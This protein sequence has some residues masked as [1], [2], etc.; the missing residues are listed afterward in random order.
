MEH[1]EEYKKIKAY[2]G[3]RTAQRSGVKLM[4]HIEEGV[5][6]LYR[7]PSSY[8]AIRAFMIHPIVQGH[9]LDEDDVTDLRHLSSYPLA[10]E[11]RNFANAFL[12]KPETDHIRCT[13]SLHI[14]LLN[15]VGYKMSKDCRD[16]LIADKLQNRK[17][18]HIYHYGS[19]ARSKELDEYFDT[20]LCY[21]NEYWT[22]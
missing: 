14:L 20:W 21:L 3:G 8:L 16:M 12:C 1:T 5:S 9:D 4:N 13:N 6:I 22:L 7:I 17:D 15:T 11:Y 2:Y 19:H 10:V 18:F